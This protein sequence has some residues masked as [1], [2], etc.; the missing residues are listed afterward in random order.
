VSGTDLQAVNPE[1]GELLEHLDQQPPEALAEVLDNIHARQA[2]LKIWSDALEGELRR[3]LKII[4]R[5]L[6]VFGEWEVESR[7]TR[8]REWDA[9][10]LEGVLRRLVDEGAVK[11]GEVA[12]VIVRKPS[13]AG[14]Q[15]LALRSRL[16]GEAQAAVDGTFA[17]K[18]KPGP[19]TVAKSVQLPTGEQVRELKDSQQGGRPAEAGPASAPEPSGAGK[20]RPPAPA[21]ADSS[22]VGD[23]RRPPSLTPEELFA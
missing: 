6:E 22:S 1:T 12:D 16:S 14:K 5:N 17:W 21:P 7:P 23:G 8:S 9:D 2:R 19:V 4:G 10:E 3:R 18:E 11:A 20:S 15:A 13:V